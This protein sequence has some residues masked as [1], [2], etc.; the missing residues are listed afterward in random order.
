MLPSLLDL[1]EGRISKYLKTKSETL[2][3]KY[4][5]NH[6]KKR[7]KMSNKKNTEV[8]AVATEADTNV[9][10][11]KPKAGT[12]KP[13]G[14]GVGKGGPKTSPTDGGSLKV[15]GGKKGNYKKGGSINK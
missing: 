12:A 2:Y 13:S 3:T 15:K 6:N 10:N 11:M 9:T 7:Q 1:G 14:A 4:S 5:L 8:V